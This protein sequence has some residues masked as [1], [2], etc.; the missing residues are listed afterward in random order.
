MTNI[1]PLN[2]LLCIIYR[3]TFQRNVS[4]VFEI[5]LSNRIAV[6]QMNRNTFT[7]VIKQINIQSSKSTV[8][9]VNMCKSAT[10]RLT[11]L[12]L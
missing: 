7:L 6:F 9:I 11:N 4:L 1:I 2:I 3:K 5:I 8:Y 12:I 10:P